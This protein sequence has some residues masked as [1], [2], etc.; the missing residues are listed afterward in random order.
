M[1]GQYRY[2]GATG[3][4]DFVDS[5]LFDAVHVLVGED[6]SVITADGSPVT[7]YVWGKYW[8]NNH[9]HVLSGKGVSDELLFLAL[10]NADVR[11]AITGAVQA[12]LSMGNLKAVELYLP[13][14]GKLRVL[15][16]QVSDLFA[17]LRVSEDESCLLEATRD[18]LLPGLIS[19]RIRA[20]AA[21]EFVEAS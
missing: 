18:T 4:F 7:Q 5:Y 14:K 10:R 9:A 3:V 17:G 8:V 2:F 16:E 1:P 11:S 20:L 6:G 13:D 12:K 15:E 21:P 19:G